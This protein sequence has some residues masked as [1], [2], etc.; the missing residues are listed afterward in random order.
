VLSLRKEMSL[1]S[2]NR[3]NKHY[4]CLWVSQF[5]AGIVPHTVRQF[6]GGENQPLFIFLKKS[7]NK[8]AL[9]FLCRLYVKH[10]L[11]TRESSS[12]VKPRVVFQKGTLLCCYQ[13]WERSCFGKSL[14]RQQWLLV[15]CVCVCVRAC[16]C[17]CAWVCV[18]VCEVYSKTESKGLM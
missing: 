6:L 15:N 14:Q 4:G 17:A 13:H 9:V 3:N 12:G 1:N 8:L 7:T 18:C 10:C 16:A 11:S 5:D 2:V